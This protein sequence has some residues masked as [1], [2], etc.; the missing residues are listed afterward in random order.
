MASRT[1][2]LGLL[3]S[4]GLV[5]GGGLVAWS[6]T[7]PGEGDVVRLL[8][9]GYVATGLCG[10]G[11]RHAAAFRPLHLAMVATADAAEATAAPPPLWEGLG[12]L[13]YKVTTGSEQAQ[14]Y[15]DQGFRLTWAFNHAEA[16]RAFREAER[17]DPQCAMCYWGEAFVLGPNINAPM[18][19]AAKAPALAAVR[20]AQQL[21]PQASEREQALIAAL[22]T[23]YSDAPN[24][25]RKSLDRAYADAMAEVQ[26]RFPD[27]QNIAVLFADSVMNTSPWDYW[28]ADHSTPKGRVGVA[29]AAI[30]QVLAKN[31]ENPAAIHLYIHL[32]EASTTP[33]RAEPY[34]DRLG[35]LMPG[36]GHI[37]HM[38]SH[39]YY[40]IGRY[41]DA[42]HANIAAAAVDEAYLAKVDVGSVHAN[43]IYPYGYYPHN[44][45][46]ELASAQM[47][48]DGKTSVAASDKLAGLIPDAVAAKVGLVQPVKAAP[49]FAY[50]Q[51]AE[52]D[53]ILALPD[54]GQGFPYLQGMWHYARGAA[55][56]AR[57]ELDGAKTEAAQIA[58]LHQ[59]GDFRL[60]QAWQVPAQDILQLARHVLEARIAQADGRLDQ[61]IEEFRVAVQIQDSIPYMEPPYW[62]YPVRQSLGAALLAAGRN[63]EAQAVFQRALVDAPNNGWALFGLMQAETAQGDAA[64]AE[65]TRKL[66]ERAWAGGAPP[67]LASL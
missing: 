56:V 4:T 62:Y 29:V 47:A 66:F 6:A 21:A 28:E 2:K 41:L 60:L 3:L 63:E 48:G 50:A 52:W 12:D 61:A 10:R 13:S 22:A 24:A 16:L 42:L 57:G 8:D 7:A 23:R 43:G 44:V 17:Q 64:G 65:A 55:L 51:F 32:T 49:Y 36:A 59:N 34:A 30:E 38:P 35:R 20:K 19:D 53:K 37:V 33:E 54:P 11:T 39:T 58:A 46:F 67:K 1:L 9:P 5:A 15:F 14:R 31:P 40:R 18:D 26:T 27:D 25:D 45:H